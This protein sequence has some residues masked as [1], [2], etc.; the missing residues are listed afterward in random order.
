M[1]IDIGRRPAQ[2]VIFGRGRHR[3]LSRTVSQARGM[4][5]INSRASA[6]KAARAK[7]ASPMLDQTWPDNVLKPNGLL[8]IGGAES[9]NNIPHQLKYIRPSIYR[10]IS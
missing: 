2:R 4:E 9:L 7:K 1:A 8:I 10:K 6:G 5:E 3:W